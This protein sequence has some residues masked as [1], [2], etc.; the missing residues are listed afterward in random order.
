MSILYSY[1]TYCYIHYPNGRVLNERGRQI[2]PF[3]ERVFC[4]PFESLEQLVRTSFAITNLYFLFQLENYHQNLNSLAIRI[5][6][7]LKWIRNRKFNHNSTV[8]LSNI[9]AFSGTNFHFTLL[10]V[11]FQDVRAIFF[12][13]QRLT[14]RI[15]RVNSQISLG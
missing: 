11:I 10:Q 12:F 7:W 5:R 1:F 13:Y 6:Y 4:T 8:K 3:S 14:P 15:R 2:W 9:T